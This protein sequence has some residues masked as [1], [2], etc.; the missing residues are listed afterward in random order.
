MTQLVGRRP[1]VPPESLVAALRPPP[2]FAGATFASYKP[3]PNFPSQAHARD[4]VI[5]FAR[6]VKKASRTRAPSR[7]TAGR[8]VYLDG[9]FGVGKTHLLAALAHE[10]GSDA[11]F[12]TF[13]EFT[14]LVGA[15]GF[16]PARA[17]LQQFRVVCI[18]EFELDDPGDTLL[19][20]RL[21]RELTDTGVAIAATSNTLPESLGQGRFAAD[22]FR[23]EIQAVAAQFTVV[24][25]D[26][27]DYRH[28]GELEFVSTSADAVAAIAET[29]G[30]VVED[31][32]A[33]VADLAHVHP[34]RL[35][36]YVDQVHTLGLTDVA[37]LNDQSSAL[38]VV[39][40]VDRLYDRDVRV[41]ASGASLGD[42][43][44]PD[45]LRGGYRKKYFRALSRLAAMSGPADGA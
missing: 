2:H 26:G 11:A 31:W 43:F 14:H 37:P 10:V 18:D 33:L 17:A 29:P 38:R 28:R 20:A 13:V 35:G 12:G 3:D 9:G 36:A 24:T 5:A 42:V 15:L 22:D 41:V 7:S 39:T 6:G 21:M 27:P 34:S 30:G 32:E 4:E 25:I 45:M 1:V 44:P 23:R 19:I 8:G 40:L 16:Q